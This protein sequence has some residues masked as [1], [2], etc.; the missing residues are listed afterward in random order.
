[1]DAMAMVHMTVTPIWLLIALRFV[2]P[3]QSV[4]RVNE[5]PLPA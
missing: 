5:H 2:S 4:S 1:V 3:T